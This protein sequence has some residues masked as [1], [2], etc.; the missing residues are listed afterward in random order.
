MIHFQTNRPRADR[1]PR[2]GR[3][4]LFGL[5]EGWPYKVD[6]VPIT[7]RAELA[8]RIQGRQTWWLSAG[9]LVWRS[10]ERIEGGH[11]QPRPAVLASHDCDVSIVPADVDAAHVS[12]VVRVLAQGSDGSEITESEVDTFMLLARQLGARVLTYSPDEPPF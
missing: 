9:R 12:T 1:C 4:R 5:A 7:L 11:N 8:A 2:C 6:P 10:P 3:L